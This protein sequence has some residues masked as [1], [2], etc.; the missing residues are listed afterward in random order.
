LDEAA[1]AKSLLDINIA[2]GKAL[3]DLDET[4]EDESD[5]KKTAEERKAA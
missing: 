5:T 1:R 3:Q 2:A 4:L